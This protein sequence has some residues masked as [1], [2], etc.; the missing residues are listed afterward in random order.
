LPDAIAQASN[1]EPFVVAFAQELPPHMVK[2][3]QTLGVEVRV[4][5]ALRDPVSRAVPAHIATLG[6]DLLRDSG[7][8]RKLLPGQ[9]ACGK[10]GTSETRCRQDGFCW[11]AQRAQRLLGKRAK[12]K[13]D[14]MGIELEALERMDAGEVQ[15]PAAAVNGNGR[16]KWTKERAIAS[17]KTFHR[18]H[19]RP[20]KQLELKLPLPSAGYLYTQFGGLQAA[21]REAGFEP[22]GKSRRGPRA[23][24]PP[25]AAKPA[26]EPAVSAPE[27]HASSLTDQVTRLTELNV[28]L[29]ASQAAVDRI[30]DEI[31]QLAAEIAQ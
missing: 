8:A 17:I 27:P 12:R 25:P 9:S 4:R 26:K 31:R 1:G 6:M 3:M 15:Q 30:T 16:G 10:C 13:E 2:L 5:A 20:P 23:V 7:P 18:E 22:T 19:G 14:G 29:K 11:R 21:V 28:R 24:K